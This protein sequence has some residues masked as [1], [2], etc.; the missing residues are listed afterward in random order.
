MKVKGNAA[1]AS[2]CSWGCGY[3]HALGAGLVWVA[4]LPPLCCAMI[5][6][7]KPSNDTF[8]VLTTAPCHPR[9]RGGR[10]V[11]V[12]ISSGRN[13]HVSDFTG[14]GGRQ[15][16][17]SRP[18]WCSALF[19]GLPCSQHR[20]T[21]PHF[22][23]GQAFAHLNLSD[24]VCIVQ[25]SWRWGCKLPLPLVH[26]VPAHPWDSQDDF[27]GSRS[28]WGVTCVFLPS[29]PWQSLG[30]TLKKYYSAGK[31]ILGLGCAPGLLNTG[32]ALQSQAVFKDKE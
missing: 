3:L 11:T 2:L 9:S 16:R 13:S 24:R 10:K 5:Y 17:R 12:F 26:C 6:V 31:Q 25:T 27:L 7:Q 8:V 15:G 14:E 18:M 20:K 22:P 28:S 19:T 1:L 4:L 21:V 29:T 32:D 23:Y 30:S